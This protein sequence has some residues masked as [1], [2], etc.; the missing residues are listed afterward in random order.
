MRILEEAARIVSNDRLEEYG[1]I[2]KS[3]ER[4]ASL[5]G[6]YL[7][8]PISTLDVCK[9]MILLK[10]SRTTETFHRDSWVDIAG[11]VECADKLTNKPKEGNHVK[12]S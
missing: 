9:L 4:I 1:D 2:H 7:D 8:R 3:F 10:V 12:R 6:T 11:Y 5:W